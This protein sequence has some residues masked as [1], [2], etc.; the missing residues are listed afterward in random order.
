MYKKSN[1]LP[2]RQIEVIITTILT[3]VKAFKF[4]LVKTGSF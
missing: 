2:E 3:H 4:S 1:Y